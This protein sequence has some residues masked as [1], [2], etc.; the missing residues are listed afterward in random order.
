MAFLLFIGF[1]PAPGENVFGRTFMLNFL[2]VKKLSVS[3]M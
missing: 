2:H 3:P 1:V